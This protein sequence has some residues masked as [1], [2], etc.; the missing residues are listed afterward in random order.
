[1]KMNEEEMS[2][3]FSSLMSRE[4]VTYE[5]NLKTLNY[6]SLDEPSE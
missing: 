5:R 4:T 1:M 2:E 3:L 6:A